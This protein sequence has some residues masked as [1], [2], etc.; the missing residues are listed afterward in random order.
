MNISLDSSFATDSIFL[1]RKFVKIRYSLMY[2][3]FLSHTT[4]TFSQHLTQTIRGKVTDKQNKLPLPGAN[5]ILLDADPPIGVAGDANGN[6]RLDSIK[7]GRVALKVSFI[8][9]N[10]VVLNNLNLSSAKELVVNMELEETVIRAKEVE[11]VAY[12]DKD[13]PINQMATVSARTFSV[14]QSQRFA[15]SMNDVA[16]MA[17]NYAGAQNPDDSRNDI[18]IR[19]NSPL[20][21]LYRLEGLD[22]PNP[23][24]FAAF[25]TTGGPISLLNN[26]VLANS[27][28]MTG[29]FPAEYGNALSGVF[30]IRMRNGN[31]EKHEFIGQIGFN[32]AEL[33]A[34]G[35]FSKKSG[36]SY[37]VSY[38]YSTLDLFKYLGIKFG[39]LSVPK[40]QDV[41]FKF[42]FQHK[43]GS[44]SVFGLGGIS[45]IDLLNRDLDTSNNLYNRPD[46]DV[47]F[48]SKV[49]AA[50]VS[51]FHIFNEKTYLKII[52]G[53]NGIVN[54]IDIDSVNPITRETALRKYVNRS[55][56]NK[57]AAHLLLN[58]KFSPRHMLRVGV[59]YEKMFL[60]IVD[61]A[62]RTSLKGYITLS[63]FTGNTD[64]IRPYVQWQYR[65]TNE[66][67][68]NIGVHYNQFLLNN[69]RNAE[70][71][72]GARYSV[73]PIDAVSFG[74]GLHSQLQPVQVYFSKVKTLQGI[75]AEPNKNLDFTRSHHLV[76]G[77]DRSLSEFMRVKLETYYQRIFNAPV[78]VTPGP[79]SMLNQGADFGIAAPDSMTNNGTGYNYGAE[80]T[81]ERFLHNGIYF[82]FTSS[83]FQ[84]RFAGSDGIE[85]NTAFN[86][87]YIFNTLAGKEFYL[88][89]KRHA[90]DKKN[91]HIITCDARLSWVGGKRY[92]PV[93]LDKSRSM[94]KAV[95]DYSRALAEKYPDYLRFDLRLGYKRQGKKASQE[96][97]FYL[98]NV[99]DRQ[100]VFR[101]IYNEK[102]RELLWNYQIGFLP[103]VQYRIEF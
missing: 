39:T 56:L 72:A 41:S 23:N 71:R 85:R 33:L 22:I 89:K 57:G 3:L 88:F 66:L 82:L 94:H 93:D 67:T 49:G 9:Y 61:S 17:S 36:A 102:S 18:V 38:R 99:T 21:I 101:Q 69:S 73:S 70:P 68:F 81:V 13:K 28:F 37:L 1:I 51:H 30:D 19:G 15:G 48:G 103:V 65:A 79:Y 12:K 97:S 7:T 64:L 80:L 31:N 42:H 98:Q 74:Y 90:E 53:A 32:G 58:K 50:G 26:N 59:L 86:G 46:E 54:T 83:L 29:A 24:H 40:Y 62:Y 92:T 5:V 84:S 2:L 63:E 45:R 27:D 77:Y 96:W 60:N 95:Y 87:N 91:Q 14:E 52:I 34:E 6:F 78:D 20:G 76:L 16:R 55:F 25:G 4:V 44:T 47:Y 11:I 75:D 10:P 8:G 43:H 35:P 100:N